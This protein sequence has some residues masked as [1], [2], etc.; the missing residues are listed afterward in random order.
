MNALFAD[1]RD[2]RDGPRDDE[3]NEE[4]NLGLP[5]GQYET[6]AG[7]VLSHLGRI[8]R[9][10]EHLRY[11]DLKLAILEMEGNKIDRILV[12]READAAAKS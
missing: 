9:Q 1:R 10:G 6:V 7:F 8:P 3:A 11:K 12:T 5:E 4:L 2:P